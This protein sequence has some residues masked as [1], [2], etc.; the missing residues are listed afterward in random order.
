MK[1]LK[2]PWI[3]VDDPGRDCS[4]CGGSESEKWLVAKLGR[5]GEPIGIA[6][7]LT[8]T[9]EDDTARLIAAAPDLL[10]ACK[11]ALE[12]LTGG[13]KTMWEHPESAY[14][15]IHAAIAKAL[16]EDA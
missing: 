5:H 15:S 10:S 12:S 6:V 14:Y 7:V 1:E 3:V 16:G 11:F 4:E 2:E 13:D 8:D 9:R